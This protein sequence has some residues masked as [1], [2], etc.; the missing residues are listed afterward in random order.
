MSFIKNKNEG[1][2]KVD[3]VYIVW[4]KPLFMKIFQKKVFML[5][6]SILFNFKFSKK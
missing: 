1:N 6:T 3:I 5:T 2:S 4:A